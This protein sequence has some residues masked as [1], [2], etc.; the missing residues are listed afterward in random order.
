[1]YSSSVI[2]FLPIGPAEISG[3]L[4]EF[5]PPTLIFIPVPVGIGLG[6]AKGEDDNA[7]GAEDEAD[8]KNQDM[9]FLAASLIAASAMVRL[10]DP[11][12]K[13][14]CQSRII[15]QDLT[16]HFVLFSG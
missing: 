14:K 5:R 10:A 6:R 3:L 1:L 8:D 13:G 12:A 16:S 15:Y 4:S 11:S 9:H 2:P 7:E